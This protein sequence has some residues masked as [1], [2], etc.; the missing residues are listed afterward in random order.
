[1][2]LERPAHDR[3]CSSFQDST[4]VVSSD[5]IICG[6][7]R[8]ISAHA[9]IQCTT[10]GVAADVNYPAGYPEVVSVAAVDDSMKHADFSNWNSD[11]EW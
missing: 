9:N 1:M 6:T 7:L 3:Q 5:A 2:S 8:C 11:V 4:C 10:V